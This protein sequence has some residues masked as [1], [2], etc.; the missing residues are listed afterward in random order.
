ML[1]ALAARDVALVCVG[2]GTPAK[3]LQFCDHVGF[4][5]DALFADPTNGCYDALGL[6]AGVATTFFDPATPRAILARVQAD[7]RAADLR[8][9][10]ARW[11]PWIPPKLSQGLQQ[12]GIIVFDG[13]R[14]LFS[15]YDPSTGA[16]ASL[17]EVL[18]VALDSEEKASALPQK[19]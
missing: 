11:Q 14:T 9:A 2:I 4:P 7:D 13:P 19:Q 6:K 15:H 10:L 17:E 8:T 5:T 12:G 1:P 16:H 3:A 18:A